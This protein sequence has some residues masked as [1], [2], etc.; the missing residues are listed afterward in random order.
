MYLKRIELQGFKSF[1]DKT[2]VEVDRGLTAI[3]GP[4]GSG[5]S[6]ISDAVRWVLGEQSAKTLRGSKMEDVI[7]AGTEKR[8]PLSFAEVSLILDNTSGTLSSEYSEVMVTRR[9]FRSGESEYYINKSS[10]RMKDV[11]EL[12]MDTG[13]GRD[14]YSIVGQGKIDEILS[15]KSDDRRQVFE[16]A[17]GISKYRFRKTEAERKLEKTE[18]NLSR[19]RD[20][21]SEITERLEPLRV[22]SEKAKMYLSYR[23][24]LRKT[25]VSTLLAVIDAKRI[26]SFENEKLLTS[27]KDEFANAKNEFDSLDE[28]NK[29]AYDAVRQKDSEIEEL[30]GRKS[31]LETKKVSVS[32]ELMLA[33]NDISN[34]ESNLKLLKLDFE[35]F[36]KK[37]EAEILQEAE[38]QKRISDLEEK[39]ATAEKYLEERNKQT[40]EI[41]VI[42]SNKNRELEEIRVLLSDIEK[43]ESEAKSKSE[44]V[45]LILSN[46]ENR[47]LS[48]ETDIEEAT[49]TKEKLAGELLFM[50][51]RENALKEEADKYKKELF[52]IGQEVIKT[53]K[54]VDELKEEYNK[55]SAKAGEKNSKANMLIEMENS[56]E[57]YARGVRELIKAKK[58]KEYHG[59]FSGTLSSLINV[60]KKY[61]SAI[62][63][64]LGNTMQNIVVNEENDA[65]KAIEY[66]KEN[67]LGRVTFLVLSAQE[68]R[69]LD[70]EKEVLGNDGVLCIASD[71]VER[72]AFLDNAI[73]ALLG[74]T[75]ICEDLK[76]AISLAKKY[77]YRFKIV[78]LSG[79]ILQPGG[80]ITGGSQNKSQALLGR[81]EE[82]AELKKD[83]TEFLKK[84]DKTEEEIY[85]LSKKLSLRRGEEERKREELSNKESELVH[86]S[87]DI[88]LK[89]HLLEDAEGR[90][91]RF[92]NEK[93]DLY[94]QIT[95]ADTLTETLKKDELSARDE[96]EKTKIQEK[97]KQEEILSVIRQRDEMSSVILSAR[98]DIN[99]LENSITL[100]ETRKRDCELRIKDLKRENEVKKAQYESIKERINSINALLSTRSDATEEIDREIDSVKEQITKAQEERKDLEEALEEV[101]KENKTINDKLLLLQE[102]CTRLESKKNRI[103]Y[104]IENATN[105]LWDEYEL[106]YNTALEYKTDITLSKAQK[107]IADLKRSIKEL[108]NVN[109]DAI[110]EYKEVKERYE[111][112]SGQTK[113]LEEAK[114]SLLKLISDMTKVMEQQFKERF[115]IINSEFKTAFID[116]FGGGSASVYLADENNVLESGIEIEIQPPG[117]KLQNITLLSGGER[118]LTA[119][120][121]LF[122]FLKVMPAPFL[123]LDEIESA[124]D[125]ENVYR[126]ADYMKK[127]NSQTQF[128][129]ITHRRGTME[130]A[131][132]LYGVTMQEKGVSKLLSMKLSEVGKLA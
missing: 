69:R 47:K 36:D 59:E 103:D 10:C 60:E 128:I 131:E 25:E 109:V 45:Q 22:Q 40:D 76:S 116:L 93:E 67:S 112:L 56:L 90:E 99:T 64:A 89:E 19:V 68:K 61:V 35:G 20:I 12:F 38:I 14:G 129:V 54:R 121:L 127:Y 28:K 108:G 105:R 8:K 58:N 102:E 75:V 118:A 125:D 7:F 66:L 95:D 31:E 21:L 3:V 124:L 115:A 24:A 65:K 53:S 6:N 33:Q 46:I 41:S 29:E 83:A 126:F 72:E 17:S 32:G 122:A 49:S 77:K 4:N 101:R 96:K 86:I 71:V 91:K 63:S 73:E 106:T 11:H 70:I 37:R 48:I 84:A 18:E 55:L 23:D 111:F 27:A 39:K 52:D 107:E 15:A 81:K 42:L 104:D 74:R 26:A 117:K 120:A 62:E 130:A 88:S 78:T 9:M 2:T 5:K 50:K 57:G 43:K 94:R 100:E 51:E 1:V 13:L 80:S 82:I 123:I 114:A 85:S 97:T 30:H 87:A 132:M 98:T 34:L 44:S 79:E 110:E 113:D 119:I 16:E 92:A